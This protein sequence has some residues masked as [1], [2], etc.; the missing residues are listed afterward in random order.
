MVWIFLGLGGGGACT[1]LWFA[2]RV[3]PEAV[4]LIPEK[5]QV[6]GGVGSVGL[7][8][9]KSV[10]KGFTEYKEQH[11]FLFLKRKWVFWKEKKG[12]TSKRTAHYFFLFKKKN[13]CP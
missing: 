5:G 10:V 9:L 13:S 8:P 11:R 2:C 7:I 3:K 1:Q 6:Q 12:K 4:G